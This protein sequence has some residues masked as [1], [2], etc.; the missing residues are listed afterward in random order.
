MTMLCHSGRWE[1]DVKL[2]CHGE[3]DLEVILDLKSELNLPAFNSK[4]GII[5]N[6][7][8]SIRGIEKH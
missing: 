5:L 2:W 3:G 6:L 1:D 4:Q 8:E 7:E